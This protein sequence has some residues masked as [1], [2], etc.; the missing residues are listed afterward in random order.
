MSEQDKQLLEAFQQRR[1]CFDRV[2]RE[3]GETS[4]FTCPSCGFPTLDERGGYDICPVCFWEDSGQDDAGADK[5]HGGPNR[6]ISLTD[7]RL[8]IERTLQ[9]LA[10][11]LG[12]EI[13]QDYDKVQQAL[14]W[15]EAESERMA[16]SLMEVIAS[17]P[18]W[19][20]YDKLRAE[21]QA[22][23]IDKDGRP[24]NSEH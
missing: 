14:H 12:G 1:K 7:S 17:D 15:Y 4:V 24:N 19:H 22:K 23:L 2:I 6:N 8:M 16:Q 13:Q 5:I 9:E 11:S 20:E 18:R 3:K 21:L 10:I